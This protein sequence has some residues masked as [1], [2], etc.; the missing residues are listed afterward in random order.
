MWRQKYLE[1]LTSF[2][3][4]KLGP[5]CCFLSI[6]GGSVRGQESLRLVSSLQSKRGAF[7]DSPESKTH[8]SPVTAFEDS[9]PAI[10]EQQKSILPSRRVS[11]FF[12]ISWSSDKLLQGKQH[13]V[14]TNNQYQRKENPTAIKFQT[15]H[16][17][18]FKC[19]SPQTPSP[20]WDGDGDECTTWSGKTHHGR[21]AKAEFYLHY[22]KNICIFSKHW[23]RVFSRIVGHKPCKYPGFIYPVNNPWAKRKKGSVKILISNLKTKPKSLLS[24]RNKW[25]AAKGIEP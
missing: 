25:N 22:N 5:S 13:K 1:P 6:T 19:N 23:A 8:L 16:P 3:S 9:S 10:L 24:P 4:S 15:R 11:Y 14:W 2:P 20:E 12:G 17:K 21:K 18:R 7:P